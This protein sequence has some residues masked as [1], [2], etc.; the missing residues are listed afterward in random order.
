M[1]PSS[2]N[3]WQIQTDRLLKTLDTTTT[4][5]NKT[6][7]QVT[8]LEWKVRQQESIIRSYK[9]MID[10]MNKMEMSYAPIQVKYTH[11]KQTPTTTQLSSTSEES[12]SS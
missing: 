4:E 1:E 8:E 6:Y 9:I 10:A 7:K 2:E 11:Q 5:L 12:V 3:F